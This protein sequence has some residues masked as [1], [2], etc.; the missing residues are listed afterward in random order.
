M[1][2]NLLIGPYLLSIVGLC[3]LGAGM[4]VI[5]HYGHKETPFNPVVPTVLW[6]VLSA[7]G[8][9]CWA[10]ARYVNPWNL[11]ALAVMAAAWLLT[12]LVMPFAMRKQSKDASREGANDTGM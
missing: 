10:W 4:L 1:E 2:G 5:R 7:V 11:P 12:A 8:F 3:V 6:W 9:A